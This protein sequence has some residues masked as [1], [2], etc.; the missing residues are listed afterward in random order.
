MSL[1]G[2]VLIDESSSSEASK[3]SP[4]STCLGVFSAGSSGDFICG[5][6]TWIGFPL[7][8]RF[9]FRYCHGSYAA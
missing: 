4:A 6:V 2:A 3:I 9:L 1:S 7:L 5:N 8:A